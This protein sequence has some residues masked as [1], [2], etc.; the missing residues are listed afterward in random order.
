MISPGKLALGL[1]L[2][3]CSGCVGSAG[4]PLTEVRAAFV[5][6]Q[7]I[8]LGDLRR[9]GSLETGLLKGLGSLFLFA[10]A[11]QLWL[12][13]YELLLSDSEISSLIVR[14]A[15]ANVIRSHALT[16]GM[17]TLRD[18]GLSKAAAGV[19]TIEEVLRVTQEDYADLPL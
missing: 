11:A 8:N 18:D 2:I 17:R 19:T 15:P 5:L 1:G 3:L 12:G 10:V 7:E 6:G 14:R 4:P 16:H 9:L 13:R